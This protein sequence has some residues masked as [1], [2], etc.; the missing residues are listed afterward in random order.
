MK[1]ILIPQ[2]TWQHSPLKWCCSEW[3]T[4]LY[5]IISRRLYRGHQGNGSPNCPPKSIFS[6][7]GL[8]RNLSS[9]S[10]VTNHQKSPPPLSWQCT[11]KTRNHWPTIQN[12]STMKQDWWQFRARRSLLIHILVAFTHLSS[13]IQLSLDFRLY[14]RSYYK[15]LINTLLLNLSSPGKGAQNP[16]SPQRRKKPHGR[17]HQSDR[18]MKDQGETRSPSSRNHSTEYLPH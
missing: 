9:A 18:E 8:R 10:S 1:E 7:G 3:Q 4:P 14:S 5:A 17:T 16:T 15:R 11:S 6:L 13:S 12:G 2:N